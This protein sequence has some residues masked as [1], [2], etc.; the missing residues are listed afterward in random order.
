MRWN[1]LY[2]ITILIVSAKGQKIPKGNLGVINSY[3]PKYER[4]YFKD[5]CP[6]L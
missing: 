3:L 4:K 6:S 5:F 2:F 1:N